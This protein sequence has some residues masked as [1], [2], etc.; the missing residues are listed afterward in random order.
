MTRLGQRGFTLLEVTVS[1]F[2][3]VVILGVAT[4][5]LGTTSEMTKESDVHTLA[6]AEHRR[7]LT[8]VAS[9]LRGVSGSTLEGFDEE[10]I[11]TA[12]LFQ[13]VT[14]VDLRD[15]ELTEPQ[16]VE[17]RASSRPVSGVESPGALWL[18]DGSNEEILAD[19]VPQGGFQVRREGN[20]LAIRLTTY[21]AR[22]TSHVARVTSETAVSL[23]N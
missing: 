13:R 14:G 19:R 21:Y 23:R 12:P 20:V 1:S 10:G 2:L 5:L 9:V 6:H 16:R 3:G 8:Y 17:W 7:N 4:S 22:S 18:V 11:S 15:R